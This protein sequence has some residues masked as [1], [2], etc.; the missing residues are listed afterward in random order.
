MPPSDLCSLRQ[1]D[2]TGNP[3]QHDKY[4]QRFQEISEDPGRLRGSHPLPRCGLEP[5]VVGQIPLALDESDLQ[6]VATGMD[7]IFP[8]LRRCLGAEYRWG[9]LSETIAGLLEE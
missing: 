9:K 8:S 3:L 4:R 2:V 7:E 1:V 5:L 6:I